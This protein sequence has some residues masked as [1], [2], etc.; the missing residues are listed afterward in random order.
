MAEF[1]PLISIFVGMLTGFY[2]LV[3]Y[4]LKQQ[5]ETN[6]LD[7]EERIALTEAFTRV[8]EATENAAREAKE[9]NGHLAEMELQ[10][11]QLF[12]E[13]ADRNCDA[14][15][16]ISEQHVQRQVVENEFV[17]SLERTSQSKKTRKKAK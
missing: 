14:I 15:T 2:A 16:N 9:R 7:R 6:K 17:A 4:L 12:K 11:Q 3:K 8:A 1:I 13:L 10:S 5:A